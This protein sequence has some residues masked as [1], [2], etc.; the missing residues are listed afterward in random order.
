[1]KI[2]VDIGDPIKIPDELLK[3]FEKDLG[4]AIK[5]GE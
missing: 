4:R 3:A 5:Q 1:M 2:K